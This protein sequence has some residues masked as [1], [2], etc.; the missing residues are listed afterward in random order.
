MQVFVY[1]E[2]ERRFSNLIKHNHDI[3]QMSYVFC[4]DVDKGH[5]QIGKIDTT[6]KP[7]KYIYKLADH[8]VT[9]FELK[10]FPGIYVGNSPPNSSVDNWSQASRH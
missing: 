3:S 9:I 6:K 1:T 7:Y 8:Y 4:W 10:N 5:V 2:I